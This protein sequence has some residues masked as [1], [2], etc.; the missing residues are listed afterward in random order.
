MVLL[1]WFY[2]VVDYPQPLAFN[3]QMRMGFFAHLLSMPHWAEA[4][5]K[6]AAQPS[7]QVHQG[8]K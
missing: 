8:A 4:S 3:E 7:M 6:Q 1:L 2:P 5:Q